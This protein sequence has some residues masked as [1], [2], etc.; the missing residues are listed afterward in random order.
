MVNRM[1]SAVILAAGWCQRI[2]GPSSVLCLGGR[3][4]AK[5]IKC[6]STRMTKMTLKAPKWIDSLEEFGN[7]WFFPHQI[8]FWFVEGHYLEICPQNYC[9]LY[10]VSVFW[11]C[12]FGMM[13]ECY[14]QKLWE[15]E[16]ACFFWVSGIARLGCDDSMHTN[17]RFFH[18]F[19]V[20]IM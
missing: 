7:A 8:C 11:G 20:I 12:V 17:V 2:G 6:D 10:G 3:R 9:F 4:Q 16:G 18:R 1:I 13:N 5:C 19:Q 14:S 15:P